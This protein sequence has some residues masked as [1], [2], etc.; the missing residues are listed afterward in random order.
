MEA[1]AEVVA[2]A[3][4]HFSGDRANPKNWERLIAAVQAL[5]QIEKQS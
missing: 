4:A 5:N 1:C 2:A 3:Q